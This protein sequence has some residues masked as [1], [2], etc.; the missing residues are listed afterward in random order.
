MASAALTQ[1]SHSFLP[2][3]EL[4]LVFKRKASA[5]RR[6]LNAILATMVNTEID[7]QVNWWNEFSYKNHSNPF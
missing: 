7:P 6:E 1:V 3:G 5:I 4:A 2:H